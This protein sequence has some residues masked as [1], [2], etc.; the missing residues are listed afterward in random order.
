VCQAA[1]FIMAPNARIA[2]NGTPKR[3]AV[4]WYRCVRQSARMHRR[5]PTRVHRARATLPTIPIFVEKLP[6]TAAINAGQAKASSKASQRRPNQSGASGAGALAYNNHMVSPTANRS[7][8]DDWKPCR[9]SARYSSKSTTVIA[10]VVARTVTLC[11]TE[12]LGR[13][14]DKPRA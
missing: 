3:Q 11:D 14:C 5:T 7:T 1:S 8:V 2:I 4:N 9:R 13:A 10:E 12:G 6:M